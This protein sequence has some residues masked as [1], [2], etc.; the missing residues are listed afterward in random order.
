MVDCVQRDERFG[1]LAD[2]VSD[3][4]SAFFLSDMEPILAKWLDDIRDARHEDGTIPRVAPE[5]RAHP[6]QFGADWGSDVFQGLAGGLSDAFIRMVWHIYPFT[7]DKVRLRQ[8]IPRIKALV[9]RL[10]RNREW[11]LGGTPERDHRS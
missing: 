6:P 5:Y 2:P 4:P 11:R 3:L 1:W 9:D 10:L 7:G 8:D